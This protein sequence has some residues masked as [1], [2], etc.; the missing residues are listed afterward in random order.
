M[1]RGEAVGDFWPDEECTVAAVGV[2][3][4]KH[5]V[6]IDPAEQRELADEVDDQ[7][8]HIVVVETIPSVV[9]RTQRQV[10][11]ARDFRMI[12][13]VPLHDFPL[14]VVE[15]LRSAAAAVHRNDQRPTLRRLGA[16]FAHH[17]GADVVFVMHLLCAVVRFQLLVDR[18]RLVRF[19]DRGA[20]GG[21][22]LGHKRI[23]R[24]VELPLRLFFFV[25]LEERTGLLLHLL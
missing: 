25:G 14:T 10:F 21:V 5:A 11:V 16:D 6:G 17:I 18:R 2:A 19:P 3:D 23:E 24:G 13:V 4:Q 1:D 8:R 22:V 7:R 12:L 15:L 9:R 20:H